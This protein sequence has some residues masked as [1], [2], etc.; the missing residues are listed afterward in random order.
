MRLTLWLLVAAL[1]FWPVKTGL[2]TGT[3]RL[4]GELVDRNSRPYAYWISLAFGAFITIFVLAIGLGLIPQ[5]G[6]ADH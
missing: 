3:V 4:R 6:V 1:F 2:R 5:G